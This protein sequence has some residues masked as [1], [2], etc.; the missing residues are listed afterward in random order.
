MVNL[1]NFDLNFLSCIFNLFL[2][3][4]MAGQ[5]T[6]FMRELTTTMEKMGIFSYLQV[7][8]GFC[9]QGQ[10]ITLNDELKVL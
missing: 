9:G 3:D 8:D 5:V 6:I 10:K 4:F 2:F 7:E 1:S